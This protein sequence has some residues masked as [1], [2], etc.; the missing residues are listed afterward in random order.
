MVIVEQVIRDLIIRT[1][2]YE[3]RVFLMRAP[4][5][6][7][8]QQTNPFAIFF[9]VSPIPMH[10]HSGPLGLIER[11]YQ[12]SSYDPSQTKV[13]GLADA[14]RAS[15]DGFV[16]EFEGVLFGGIFYR[17]QLSRYEQNTK[18][19]EVI[20]EFRIFYRLTNHVAPAAPNR[21]T[22]RNTKG[23]NVP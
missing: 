11:D 17:N 22:T 9:H 4:Q 20:Q 13:L 6:P 12:V 2:L 5:V 8:E 16:G 14:L 18:L 19:F 21:S 15:L 23:V 3:R 10:A 1:N 7:A